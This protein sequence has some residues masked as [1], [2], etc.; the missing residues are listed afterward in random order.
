MLKRIDWPERT[1][2]FLATTTFVLAGYAIGDIS[3]SVIN[4]F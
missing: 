4:L 3:M 2:Q 1:A